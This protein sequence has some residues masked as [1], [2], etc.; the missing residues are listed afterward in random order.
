MT[1]QITMEMMMRFVF[2]VLAL[3]LPPSPAFATD[4]APVSRMV[5]IAAGMGIDAAARSCG[6]RY[7]EAAVGR[8]VEGSEGPFSADERGMITVLSL[9]FSNQEPMSAADCAG[10]KA[11]ADREG[12][13]LPD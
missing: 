12:W 5:R 7:D 2:L 10:W 11:T 13:L 6:W 9:G 1:L 8:Y 4:D 3:A